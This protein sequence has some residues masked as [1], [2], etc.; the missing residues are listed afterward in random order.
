MLLR[1]MS[2]EVALRDILRTRSDCVAFG[3]KRTSMGGQGWVGQSRLTLTGRWRPSN[4]SF[5]RPPG[6]RA[7]VG[8]ELHCRV[9][10]AGIG[11]QRRQFY[12]LGRWCGSMAA[13]RSGAAG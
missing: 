7:G 1:C 3:V 4:I 13:A 12:R 8:G 5:G 10:I 6:H 9:L 11:M 2:P